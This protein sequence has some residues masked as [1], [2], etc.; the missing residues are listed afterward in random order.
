MWSRDVADI[1]D[2][3]CSAY[4]YVSILGSG[5]GLLFYGSRWVLAK[6]VACQWR[7]FESCNLVHQCR[8]YLQLLHSMSRTPLSLRVAAALKSAQLEEGEWNVI[9]GAV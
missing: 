7:C 6:S 5:E 8:G 9:K 3:W 4:D 2:L 1:S